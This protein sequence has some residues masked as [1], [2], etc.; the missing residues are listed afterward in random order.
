MREHIDTF[1]LV[2]IALLL[3]VQVFKIGKPHS[4]RKPKT[5][6]SETIAVDKPIKPSE[7]SYAK[8]G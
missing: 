1:I 3:T 2:I 5:T 7:F 6:H 8:K 4:P